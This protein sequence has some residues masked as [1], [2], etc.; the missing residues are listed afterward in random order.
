M[1]STLAV[2]GGFASRRRHNCRSRL[3]HCARPETD[4]PQPLSCWTIFLSDRGVAGP[5]LLSGR[6]C[7]ASGSLLGDSLD[8]CAV[9]NPSGV[10]MHRRAA[11]F[12][13][14][15]AQELSYR[16][17]YFECSP[18]ARAQA[19]LPGAAQLS[20]G[21]GVTTGLPGWTPTAPICRWWNGLKLHS[22]VRRWHFSEYWQ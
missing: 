2:M 22:T 15:F 5:R 17:S 20:R 19:L 4:A 14:F 10:L 16:N 11:T 7:S 8:E 18:N 9:A 1:M 21:S 3:G 6:I 12:L 13:N